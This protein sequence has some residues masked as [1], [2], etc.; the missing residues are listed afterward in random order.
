MVEPLGEVDAVRETGQRIVE[1]LAPELFLRLALRR[2]VEEIA[3]EVQRLAVLVR[4]DHALV[5]NPDPVAVAR[6]QSVLDAERLVR[7]VRPR[8]GGEDAVAV[9]GM[10][11]LDEEQLVGMPVRDRVAEDALDLAAGEDV[12]ADSVE[13]VG[14]DHERKLLHERAIPTVDLAALGSLTRRRSRARSRSSTMLAIPAATSPAPGR[15]RLGR[16]T[17]S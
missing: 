15:F 11:E 4:D 8:V 2:D 17:L 12:R 7:P 6:A 1:R 5:P 14:V 16:R 10:Q 3:L 13:R 9:L